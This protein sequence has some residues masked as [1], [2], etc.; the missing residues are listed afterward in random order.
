MLPSRI[1]ETTDRARELLADGAI[2]IEQAVEFTGLSRAEL[3][4]RM[5][6]G[7]LRFVKVGRRRLIPKRAAV[8]MLA[9]GLRGGMDA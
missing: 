8:Q 3:Y 9:A 7:S 4:R 6:A 2:G 5:D 1:D